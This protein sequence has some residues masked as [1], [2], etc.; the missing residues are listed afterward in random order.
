MSWNKIALSNY[1]NERGIIN[2]FKRDLFQLLL[3]AF[4]IAG[5]IVLL[6]FIESSR[7]F[8]FFYKYVI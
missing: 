6:Q 8:P 7:P 3:M 4:L 1:I 2:I 5:E